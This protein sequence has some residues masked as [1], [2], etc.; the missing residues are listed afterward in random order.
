MEV[1]KG[2]SL[3]SLGGYQSPA[4]YLCGRLEH[5]EF[6]RASST[7]TSVGSWNNTV[8]DLFDTGKDM[9]RLVGVCIWNEILWSMPSWIL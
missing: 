8:V 1:K 7:D 4:S 5:S 6:L 3:S 9:E 2:T